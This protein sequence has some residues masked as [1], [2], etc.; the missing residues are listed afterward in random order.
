VPGTD[1]SEQKTM[2]GAH[3]NRFTIMNFKN[4]PVIVVVALDLKISWKG[5]NGDLQKET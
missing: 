3:G 2:G 1:P 5:Y 4:L